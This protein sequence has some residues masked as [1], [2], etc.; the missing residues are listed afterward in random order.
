[1]EDVQPRLVEAAGGRD[2][3]SEEP[4]GSG[5]ATVAL[6]FLA[7]AA[8]GA[9]VALLLAPRTGRETREKLRGWMDEAAGQAGQGADRVREAVSHAAAVIEEAWNAGRRT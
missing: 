5:A 9:G 1:M 3:M 7:G 8:L 2:D 4:R 6:A